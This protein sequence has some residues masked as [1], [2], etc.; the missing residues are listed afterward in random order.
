M[1]VDDHEVKKR[2]SHRTHFKIID[3]EMGLF[4]R[5]YYYTRSRDMSCPTLIKRRCDQIYMEKIPQ[6]QI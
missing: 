3:V 2:R 4:R 1:E 5:R 6:E